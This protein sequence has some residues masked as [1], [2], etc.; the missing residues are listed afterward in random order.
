MT[1]ILLEQRPADGVVR[2]TLHRP[3]ERNALSVQLR[4]AVSDALDRLAGDATVK[5]VVLTGA[6]AVFC[7]GF[8]LR[9]FERTDPEFQERLWASADRFHARVRTFPLPLVA[10]VNGPAVAGGF[11]LAVMCDLRVA[12]E[13]AWFAHPEYA[14]SPVM[15]EP[16]HDLVGG[17]LARRLCFTGERLPAAEALRVGLVGSV[18]APAELDAAVAELTGRITRAS[19]EALLAT[20]AAVIRTNS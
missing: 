5:V 18:V 7:A 6:G 1:E 2:L 16:L 15:Y 19:R 12:V 9:E 20:K 11:D 8:D 17:A 14:F 10:A 3:D 13:G 4:E